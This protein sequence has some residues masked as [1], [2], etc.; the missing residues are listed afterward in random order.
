MRRGFPDKYAN[1]DGS[2]RLFGNGGRGGNAP[3]AK[4]PALAAADP[5]RAVGPTSSDT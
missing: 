5:S 2:A 1:F 3:R 4:R